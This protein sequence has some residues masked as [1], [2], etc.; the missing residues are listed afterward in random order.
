[1]KSL[2]EVHSLVAAAREEDPGAIPAYCIEISYGALSR[3]VI[4]ELMDAGWQIPDFPAGT[5]LE[6]S[7]A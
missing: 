4:G 6:M 5:G 2:I 3:R 7:A 1:M